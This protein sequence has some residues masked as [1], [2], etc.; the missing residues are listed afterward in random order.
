M[1]NQSTINMITE[2][3]HDI[4]IARICEILGIARS[5]YYRN[6]KPKEPGNKELK[7]EIHKVCKVAHFRFGYRKVFN[8]VK[9]SFACTEGKVRRIM[10]KNNWG[11]KVKIKVQH[12]SGNPF[13]TFDNIINRDW[14]TDTPLTKLTTDITYLPFGTCMLYLSTIMD[15]FNNE[16][17]AYKISDHPDEQLVLGTLAQLPELG[18]ETI[19][20]SDQGSTYT[21]RKVFDECR[22]KGI[23][24][25]M[26]RKGTPA[27][28]AL[29]ESFHS[30]LKSETFYINNEPIGSNSIVIEMVDE[31]IQFWNNERILQKLGYQSPVEYRL[32]VTQ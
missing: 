19:L 8:K 26:S 28:N 20:H 2:L 30:S 18:E 16:I 15:T 9:V 22:E 14:D 3:S 24:R 11:C 23:I 12:R 29:I 25:S 10:S 32:S 27:D 6:L 4:P 31:Y 7:Q 5:T 13:K 21:S 1:V 17:I